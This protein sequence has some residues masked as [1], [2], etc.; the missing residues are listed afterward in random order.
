MATSID[1]GTKVISVP[2]ADLTFIGGT[3]YQLD[4]EAFR[5]SLR[6]LEDSEAGIIFP[7][8]HNHSTQVLLGGV[9]YAR[10]IEIINGY[11]ITFE[12]TGS[13]YVVSLIG[14][15]NNILDVT[16]LGTVQI[17]SNNSAGLINVTELQQDAFQQAVHYDA[18]SSNS[19]I[20]YPNGTPLYPL[21]NFPDCVAVANSRGLDSIHIM[22]NA[23]LDTG[24]NVSNF[25]LYGDNAARST[26]AF[27]A[28]ASVSTAEITEAVVTGTLDSTCIIRQAVTFN[29]GFQGGFIFQS[30]IVGTLT[31]SGGGATDILQSFSGVDH[32]TIDMGGS[33]QSLNMQAFSGGAWI[34]NKTG[35]D[36]VDI[37]LT[38]GQVHINTSTCTNGQIRIVGA[39]EV[40][41]QNGDWLH[42]GT[43]GSLV[44]INKVSNEEHAHELWEL[45]GLDADDP[46]TV[47][48]TSRT[49]NAITQTITGDPATSVTVTRT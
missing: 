7:K 15:N 39:G 14:S 31:L 2:Q 24:D 40:I 49:T 29:L 27:N 44:V 22:G 26:L 21:N 45:A 6:D 13:P 12:E 19:G 25:S 34:T 46:L 43:Y 1:W 17:A 30:Q 4:T 8:T 9:S 35:T 32:P 28:G 23:T 41:D 3:T 47:T 42:S 36:K 11:T 10:I 37:S 33:G 20:T 5:L 18:T 48:P 16:N 38:G